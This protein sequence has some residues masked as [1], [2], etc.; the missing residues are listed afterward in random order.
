MKSPKK[1]SGINKKMVRSTPWTLLGVDPEVRGGRGGLMPGLSY[2]FC[3]RNEGSIS[4]DFDANYAH[5]IME[6]TTKLSS[7]IMG[8]AISFTHL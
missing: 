8:S 4:C 1:T 7:T 2:G 6:N 5:F 3:S